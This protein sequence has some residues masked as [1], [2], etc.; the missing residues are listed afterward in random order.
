VEDCSKIRF[1][2]DLWCGDLAIK[3]AFPVLFGIACTKD[4]S[5]LAHV[6]FLGGAIQWNVSLARVTQDWEVDAFA[7][8]RMLYL[9]RMR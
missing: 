1:W 6:E 7:L 9:A 4:A 8:F 2:Y 3:E 5:V